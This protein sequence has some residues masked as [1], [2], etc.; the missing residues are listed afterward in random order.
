VTLAEMKKAREIRNILGPCHA[1]REP[2]RR[3]RHGDCSSVAGHARVEAGMRERLG[4]WVTMR[5]RVSVSARVYL[6]CTDWRAAG[7]KT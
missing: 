4:P 5:T 6:V 1:V 7:W 3:M 2:W